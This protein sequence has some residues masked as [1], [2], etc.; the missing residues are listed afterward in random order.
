MLY[1]LVPQPGI[2]PLPSAGEA[3]SHNHWTAREVLLAY[4]FK[5]LHG[6][7]FL[8]LSMPLQFKGLG[9]NKYLSTTPLPPLSPP[10]GQSVILLRKDQLPKSV[11]LN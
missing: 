10:R 7:S 3:W 4:I 5:P 2:K 8:S 1:I 6:P 11:V 9:L